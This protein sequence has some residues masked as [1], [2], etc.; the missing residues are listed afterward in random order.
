MPL[1]QLKKNYI[2]YGVLAISLVFYSIIQIPFTIQAL[3]AQFSI[4]FPIPKHII[5]SSMTFPDQI[6]V[7]E[8]DLPSYLNRNDCIQLFII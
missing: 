4:L 1:F 8:S 6:S 7:I 2:Y 5:T 3:K